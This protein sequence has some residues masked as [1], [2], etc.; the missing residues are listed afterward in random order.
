MLGMF[1]IT[2]GG[3]GGGLGQNFSKKQPLLNF[4]WTE[5]IRNI[6]AAKG[7]ADFF[8][9]C[10][11]F[12]PCKGVIP[13]CLLCFLPFACACACVR[14]VAC[15]CACAPVGLLARARVSVCAF[16]CLLCACVRACVCVARVGA[17]A[18]VRV[19]GYARVR[20]CVRLCAWACARVLR[21]R[22]CACVRVGRKEG[23]SP[24]R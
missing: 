6:G 24:F 1:P 17:C 10:I 7:R 8:V 13:L 5:Y 12:F 2:G 16:A 19:R 4:F 9:D 22:G 11:Y 21:V 15:L 23:R 18:C 20:G 14:V 3:G